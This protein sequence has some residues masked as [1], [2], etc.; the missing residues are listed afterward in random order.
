MCVKPA[1]MQAHLAQLSLG[2]I[3]EALEIHQD[4]ADLQAKGL[5]ALGVLGQVRGCAPTMCSCWP[6]CYL[7]LQV[8]LV[9]QLISYLSKALSVQA[10]S[11]QAGTPQS[12]R[13]CSVKHWPG[14]MLDQ[15]AIGL[16]G[17]DSIHDSIR[18]MQLQIGVPKAIA[19]ALRR[20]GSSSDEVCIACRQHCTYK[21]CLMCLPCFLTLC[22]SHYCACSPLSLLCPGIETAGHGTLGTIISFA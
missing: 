15:L 22:E 1:G 17:D 12:Q 11:V 7:K 18:S 6:S 5:V 3:F 4:Q 10:L 14:Q 16:Q 19:R 9:H 8:L 2:D 21:D 20:W 13:P